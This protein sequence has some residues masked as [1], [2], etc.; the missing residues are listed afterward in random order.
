VKI[1]HTLE[2]PSTQRPLVLA[3][4]FFDGLHRGHREILRTLLRLRRPGFRSAVLTFR[5]HPSTHLRPDR[6]PPLLSTLEERVNLLAEAGIDELYLIPFDERIARL[7][8][9]A[10]CTDIVA[11]V[12]AA[13][14]LTIGENFR[15][16]SQR[17]GDATLARETLEPLGVRVVAV[18]PVL[19]SEDRISSTRIRAAILR[20]DMETANRLLG[21]SYV[22]RGTI[23]IGEGR[24]H[25][26]GFPTANLT[27]PREKT[28]P[29]DGVY[30]AVGRYDGRDYRGLVS[31]GSNPTFD[32]RTRTVE[33]WLL[34]FGGTAYGEELAL[35][36]FRF[37]REQR[38]FDE[39]E[40]LLE[41]M[42]EDATHVRFPSFLPA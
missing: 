19:D 5:N 11:G 10:F 23:A 26:L 20:G 16:G 25:D 18:P 28:L 33:A 7:D 35:R 3:I 4:G 29:A 30:A 1:H 40:G 13:S 39:I 21:E 38:K 22:V 8:A 14:A 37:I 24:G 15:F 12:L 27:V 32:G 41:Q 6:V 9:R 36:D 42:R 31:I 17:S 2:A 34:D